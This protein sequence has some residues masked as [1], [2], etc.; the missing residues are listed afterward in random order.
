[1]RNKFK[2]EKCDR[3]YFYKRSL[4]KHLISHIKESKKKSEPQSLPEIKIEEEFSE[5]IEIPSNPEILID[6]I[7]NH[8]I[9]PFIEIKN[10]LNS[11]VL[12][13]NFPKESIPQQNSIPIYYQ[14]P[15]EMIY[16]NHAKDSSK[17][18][19]FQTIKFNY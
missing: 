7:T 2:C 17:Y 5:I 18:F 6:L 11:H 9:A 10:S 15:Q 8:N 19:L 4:K 1:M 14:L 12:S 16:N 13:L 3:S